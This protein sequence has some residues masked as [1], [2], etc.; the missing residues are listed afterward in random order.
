MSP[1]TLRRLGPVAIGALA[2]VAVMGGALVAER[3]FGPPSGGEIGTPTGASAELQT[4]ADS[5][6]ERFNGTPAQRDAAGLLQAWAL[7]GAMDVCMKSQG[8]PEWD[9]SAARHAA[10]RTNALDTSVFFAHPLNHSY[11]KSLRDSTAFLTTEEALRTT[12]LTEAETAAALKCAKSTP[13]TSDEAAAAASTPPG[14]AQLRDQWWSMLS[15]WQEKYGD[16]GAYNQCFAE[17]TDGL[18]IDSTNGDSWKGELATLAPR[19]ADAPPAS[20]GAVSG[21]PTWQDFLRLEGALDEVDWSCRSDIYE[22][23]V[24]DVM[25]EIDAFVD[26][27]SLDI[28]GAES[29]WRELETRARTLDVTS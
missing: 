10:P 6:F 14:V 13:P 24:A 4:R 3:S 7:N 11:S 20:E 17:G 25:S 19:P 8:F 21:S 16:V 5:V 9:W 23:H 22:S 27:H 18:A 26:E 1:S 2:I 28:S 12:E 29:A 15:S